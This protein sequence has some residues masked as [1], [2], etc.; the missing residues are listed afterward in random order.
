MLTDTF[1]KDEL[2]LTTSHQEKGRGQHGANWQSQAGK[3]LTCSMFKRFKEFPV[4]A[5]FLLNMQVSL[6]VLDALRQLEIPN[7]AI[8]WPNDIMSHGKKLAGILIENQIKG[9]HIDSSIIG[10][11]LNV[12]ETFFDRLPQATS[13]TLVTGRTFSVEE[14]LQ[15][16]A[17]HIFEK[18][19]TIDASNFKVAREAYHAHLFR[20]DKISVFETP[21]G[22]QQNGIITGV[23]SRGKLC[24]C[25]EDDVITEYDLKEIRLLFL[26]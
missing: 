15:K 9:P 2:V 3:S 17:E 12:N 21:D 19:Q 26:I 13:L 24:I 18:L 14:V 7:L 10:I 22:V 4:E 23:S 1:V 16:V 6:G 8:K 20:K 25:N 11:G 5:Q